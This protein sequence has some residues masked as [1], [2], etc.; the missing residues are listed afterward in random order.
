MGRLK[1]E[2][3]ILREICDQFA[4]GQVAIKYDQGW[5]TLTLKIVRRERMAKH[6]S[7]MHQRRIDD[8]KAGGN[9][10]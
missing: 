3:E 1:S 5:T 9:L 2:L 4:E 6:E 10:P 8:A 7:E